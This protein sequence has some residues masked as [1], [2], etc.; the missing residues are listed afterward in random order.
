ML[1]CYTSSH[2]SSVRDF[3]SITPLFFDHTSNIG[4]M[5]NNGD[6]L[7]KPQMKDTQDLV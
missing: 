2:V 6:T 5:D 7:P 4:V 3:S 1:S